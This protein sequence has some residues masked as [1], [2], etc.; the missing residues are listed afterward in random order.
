VC[1]AL[2]QLPTPPPPENVPDAGAAATAAP[3]ARP[4]TY[5]GLTPQR[6]ERIQ[7]AL[8]RDKLDGWLFFDFRRSD[9][10]AYRL[11]GLDPSGARTRRWY[12]L[13]PARGQP[14]KLLHAIEPHALD[15]V[16]G[17][18]AT[19]TSWR[20]RDR[21]LGLLLR[22]VRRV[23]MDYSPRNEIPTV[24][25]VD[26]GT[27]ELVRSMGPEIVSSADL[28]AEL[29]STLTPEELAS[30]A[31]AAEL[32]GADL[33]SVAQE[34]AR[35]V[36][37]NKPATERELQD[38]A[39]SRWAQEGFD[40][41]GWP[42]VAADAHSADPH[43]SPPP[44]GGAVVG[45]GSV[46]L[47]DFSA[48][49][50]PAG[51]Y[52]DLTRVYFLG[53]NVPEEIQRIGGYVFQARDAAVQLLRQRADFGKLPTG[54]ELDAA[55]R[56]VIAKAGY[57]ER[58][59][60]RTGHSIDHHGHGDGVNNDDFET[61]DARRHLPDTCFSIEPGIYLPGRFGIRSEIDVCLPG[62][63]VELRGGPGQLLVPALLAR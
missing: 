50:A 9:E 45:R 10:I 52:A 48:R 56:A 57:A 12:C 58:F 11:L 62:G 37:E 23:A 1:A 20:V 47:L 63:K 22:G 21:E 8:Q 6:L 41:E 3:A 59:L 36:L 4:A 61:R 29:T 32:L 7:L 53:E 27:L 28:V 39:R 17:G 2:A 25:R 19:Y 30:Q 16:P 26:G 54:A 49:L 18:A 35:R 31:R 42:G 43:Y 5:E 51:I 15:G 40:P 34:A 38:F 55:A 13:I 24:A 44:E 46:L 33:E 14:R 60:H